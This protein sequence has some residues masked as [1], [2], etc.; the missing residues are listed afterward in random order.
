MSDEAE[1]G[2]QILDAHQELVRHVEE[3]AA[4]IRILSIVTLIVAA[5]LAVSYVYQIALPFAGT[6][7]VTVNLSDPA[8]VAAE[9][10]VML[11][12]LAWV[13]VGV[14]DLRFSWRIQNEIRAARSKEREIEKRVG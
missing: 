13:Y 1:R 14:S 2:P 12:A 7:T 5:V 3:G 8:N 10:V 9:L 11:L 6:T 4:R